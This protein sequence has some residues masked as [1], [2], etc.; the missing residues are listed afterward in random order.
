MSQELSSRSSE[1][2]KI[3][4]KRGR[5]PIRTTN[6]SK[7]RLHKPLNPYVLQDHFRRLFPKSR[8]TSRDWGRRFSSQKKSLLPIWYPTLLF[9]F[10]PTNRFDQNGFHAAASIHVARQYGEPLSH[11]HLGYP[12]RVGKLEPYPDIITLA[13]QFLIYFF[14]CIL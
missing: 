14:Y 1:R 7:A 5:R 4:K 11:C 6:L 13:P 3:G 2:R 9:P 12:V 8:S 10:P